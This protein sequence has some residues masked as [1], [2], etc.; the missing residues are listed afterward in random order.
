MRNAYIRVPIEYKN[1]LKNKGLRLKS[2]A[3]SDYYEDFLRG[4]KNSVR[5]Y[6]EAWGVSKSN[7]H[8]WIREFDR[9]IERFEI[10]WEL[11]NKPQ[12]NY[13][14]NQG[15]QQLD[16]AG[17]KKESESPQFTDVTKTGWTEG[18]QQLDKDYNSTIIISGDAKTP[19][20]QETPKS[21]KAFTEDREFDKYYQ[22]LRLVGKMFVGNR[23]DAYNA[24]K[25]VKHFIGIKV[26]TYAYKAYI[27]EIQQIDGSMTQGFAKFILNDLYL[28]YLPNRIRYF[29]K[30]V[31]KEIIGN[32]DFENETLEIDGNGKASM[33]HDLFLEKL[34]ANEIEFVLEVA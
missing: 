17:T 13:A 20:P 32:Y 24:Y 30:S 28:P 12:D 22:E 2:M 14:K 18:G 1:E 4:E 25:Q 33:P 9:E 26:L 8:N 10:Y 19:P 29:A 23:E 27:R 6:A 31:N 3:F 15:G 7:A 11:K 21:K 16:S 34:K 5:F